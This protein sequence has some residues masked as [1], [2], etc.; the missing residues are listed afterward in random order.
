MMQTP[1]QQA[2]A[3]VANRSKVVEDRTALREKFNILT[4][5]KPEE[6]LVKLAPPA[7]QVAIDRLLQAADS[8]G[9]D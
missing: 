6:V 5:E 1:K 4:S 9:S 8:N 2:Q 3:W 7:L